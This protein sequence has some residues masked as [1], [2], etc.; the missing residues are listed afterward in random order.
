[1]PAAKLVVMGPGEAGKS[2]LISRLTRGA[3]NLAVGSRTVAMDHA[4]LQVGEWRLSVVGVPGQE[5]FAPVREALFKGAAAAVWVHPAGTE[6]DASTVALL[7]AANGAVPPY[8][9][10]VNEREGG[11]EASAFVTPRGVPVPRAVIRANLLSSHPRLDELLAA[12]AG[13]LA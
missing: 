6:P 7:D 1:M 8:V 2:T 9:V 13:C 3:V 10:Y 11:V 5:R 4:A 12:V